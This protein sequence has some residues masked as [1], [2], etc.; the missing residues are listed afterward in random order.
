[1]PKVR[2]NILAKTQRNAKFRLFILSILNTKFRAV[3]KKFG[4]NVTG[5]EIMYEGLETDWNKLQTKWNVVREIA[6]F[7]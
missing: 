5:G 1:M 6:L 4:F 2:Q 3:L 7:N